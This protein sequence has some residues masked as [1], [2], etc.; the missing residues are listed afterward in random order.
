MKLT[1]KI[2]AITLI[3]TMLTM[4]L[5]GTIVLEQI[6]S[7]MQANVNQNLQTNTDYARSS[8][9]QSLEQ[10]KNITL[11]LSKDRLIRRSL[12]LLDNR[13]VNQSLNYL[14]EVHPFIKYIVVADDNN[15]VF[16]V[17]TRDTK[18][19]RIPS[20]SLLLKS[21]EDHPLFISSEIN[22]VTP[23][24]YGPDPWQELLGM[25]EG[26]SK[27]FITPILKRGKK[28]G[29]IVLVIDWQN[30]YRR[31]LETVI[32]HLIAANQP[33][34]DA[35]FADMEG[36]VLV[37]IRA[38][39]SSEDFEAIPPGTTMTHS[40]DTITITKP[41]GRYIGP[42]H[43]AQPLRVSSQINFLGQN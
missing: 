32:R 8:L 34:R 1:P 7:T 31:A 30:T 9:L 13:G 14:V 4:A 22:Q 10:V 23:G 18:G 15:R 25:E 39:T 29:L 20:E 17:S 41:G 16:A 37:G 43:E 5:A 27:W 2:V 3:P 6:R 38:N 42:L 24:P 36:R 33:V 19:G 35:F 28:I 40:D 11:G 26:L 12:D 21:L